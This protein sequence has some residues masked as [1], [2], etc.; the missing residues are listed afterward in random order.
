LKNFQEVELVNVANEI[1]NLGSQLQQLRQKEG[2][3]LEKLS[4]ESGVSVGLLSQL[5]RGIG[6]PSFATLLKIAHGLDVPIS[7]FFQGMDQPS[8][9]VVRKDQR[10]KLAL[11]STNV[12]YELL[13]PD[14]N[15]ALEFLWVELAPGESTERFHHVGEESGLV[16]QGTLEVHLGDKIYVLEEGDSISFRSNIPHWHR[17]PGQERMICVWVATPSSLYAERR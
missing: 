15:R 11:E 5:E 1:S 9:P 6:N 17:N 7:L 13:T 3:T 10:Q 2:L 16:L 8:D 12:V 14:L 4:E